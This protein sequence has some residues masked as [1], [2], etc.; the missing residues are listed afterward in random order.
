LATAIAQPAVTA[1]VSG[2]LQNL[3]AA[4]RGARTAVDLPF[5]R[6][7][8]S[9]PRWKS[10]TQQLLNYCYLQRTAREPHVNSADLTPLDQA[11]A[12]L[13][14]RPEPGEFQAQD[15]AA[16]T[17]NRG[18]LAAWGGDDAAAIRFA[19][20]ARRL[21][22]DHGAYRQMSDLIA[23]LAKARPTRHVGEGGK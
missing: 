21:D 16:A 20:E 5:V 23:R 12:D 13:A 1:A 10:A 3:D 4:W 2:A 11:Y 15:V 8:S 7:D 18:V 14:A 6:V 22:V 9:D 19:D 17:W